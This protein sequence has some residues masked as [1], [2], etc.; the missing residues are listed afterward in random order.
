MTDQP[1]DETLKLV[2][3]IVAAYVTKNPMPAGDLPAMI[4]SVH[5][6]LAEFGPAAQNA[7]APSRAMR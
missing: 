6:T 5:A 7:A 2:A 3:Q 4:R 1:E